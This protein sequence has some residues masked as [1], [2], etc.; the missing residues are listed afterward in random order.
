MTI[1]LLTLSGLL[2]GQ[3]INE[4]PAIT[5]LMERYKAQNRAKTVVKGF[6]IQIHSTTDR[7]KIQ[8]MA[9]EFSYEFPEYESGWINEAPYY[10]LKCCAFATKLDCLPVLKR[11]QDRFP[12]AYMV[13]DNNIPIDEI[14]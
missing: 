14:H 1:T 11:I 3:S 9:A 4:D 10:K 8:Q 7:T 5:S 2:I 6:R 12:G 13:V